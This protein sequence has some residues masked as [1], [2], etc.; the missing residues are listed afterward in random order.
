MSDLVF[1]EN[2]GI[3]AKLVRQ[4][5]DQYKSGDPDGLTNLLTLLDSVR[6]GEFQARRL[7]EA[8]LNQIVRM[9]TAGA[10]TQPQPRTISYE[11]SQRST[12]RQ[13]TQGQT[14]SQ[15]NR[16]VAKNEPKAPRETKEKITLDLDL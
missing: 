12:A 11:P 1:D 13:A 16:T 7:S 4:Y 15:G 5:A 10:V 3:N 8:Y 6:R 9:Q 2:P 14:P